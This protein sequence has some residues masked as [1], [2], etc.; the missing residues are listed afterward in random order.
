MKTILV[1]LFAASASADIYPHQYF[2]FQKNIRLQTDK[3]LLRTKNNLV[4][5]A[6]Q[7][8]HLLI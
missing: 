8:W 1:M 3:R 5:A 6:L 2:V 7:T 4:L